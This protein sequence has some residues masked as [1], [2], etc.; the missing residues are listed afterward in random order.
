MI[1]NQSTNDILTTSARKWARRFRLDANEVVNEVFI[2][3]LSST[4]LP[5]EITEFLVKRVRR[6]SENLAKRER[7]FLQR[8]GGILQDVAA[9]NRVPRLNEFE[10]LNSIEVRSIAMSVCNDD[11][12]RAL[13]QV[14]LGEHPNLET[15]ADVFRAFGING[16]QA[17][18]KS[19]TLEKHLKSALKPNLN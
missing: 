17:Y 12:D 1:P 7:R 5:V 15:K 13:V 9:C 18:R 10:E 2:D 3:L 8:S 4:D 16:T 14:M 11:V 19:D 6:V